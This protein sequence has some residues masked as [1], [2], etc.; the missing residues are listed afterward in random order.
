MCGAPLRNADSGS[1]QLS[2]SRFRFSRTC[3]FTALRP[4]RVLDPGSNRDTL[5]RVIMPASYDESLHNV[6]SLL[7]SANM[8]MEEW[9]R[10]SRFD[11]ER[12]YKAGT[13]PSKAAEKANQYWR[14]EQN[15]ALHQQY[16]RTAQCWLPQNHGEF[17]HCRLSA[18]TT[19]AGAVHAGPD[20]RR[21]R[22]L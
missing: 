22:I 19:W 20:S 2:P 12:E 9:Q 7:Q 15:K 6:R 13:G 21:A 3:I 14:Y 4:E 10:V 8:P 5:K 18:F 11:F 17:C 16:R 1:R